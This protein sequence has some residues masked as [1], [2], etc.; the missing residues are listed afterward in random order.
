[1][2]KNRLKLLV[3]DRP[4]I[5]LTVKETKRLAKLEAIVDKLERGENVQNRY[6]KTWL[7]EDEYVQTY[8]CM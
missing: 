5:N 3:K 2:N 7:S 6:L 8:F 4:R 1:M